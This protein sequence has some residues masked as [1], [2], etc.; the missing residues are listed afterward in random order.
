[1]DF[2]SLP[3][4]QIILV[5]LVLIGTSLGF[6][7]GKKREFELQN[8]LVQ[9]Q[10]QEHIEKIAQ[11]TRDYED[12]LKVL[13]KAN[14]NEIEK[15]N[16][17]HE[18]HITQL[19]NQHQQSIQSI[20]D[21]HLK[22]SEQ[23]NNK[24]GE[25]IQQLTQANIKKIEEIQQK[26]EQHITKV[27]AKSDEIAE[28]LQKNFD[29]EIGLTINENNK[30]KESLAELKKELFDTKH[31]IEQDNQNNMHSLSK[32][33][34]KLIR[35]VRSVQELANELDETSRTV[36]GGKYSFFE[37]IQDQRDRE[38]V[39]SLTKP[40]GNGSAKTADKLEK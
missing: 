15:I 9:D 40:K 4:L 12:K 13:N 5:I 24:H 2:T 7:L 1:M 34:D 32:S 39:L 37:E 10:T 36:S 38:T 14:V 25:L 8:K 19:N 11:L 6:K 17:S 29:K 21:G 22:E 18:Q 30:L 16:T 28:T 23:L 35:V 26:H 3:L 27:I 33:G 31:K 20:E